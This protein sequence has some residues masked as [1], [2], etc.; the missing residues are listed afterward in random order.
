MVK[1]IIYSE[2]CYTLTVKEG[3]S[4]CIC[5]FLELSEE[6]FV[7]GNIFKFYFPREVM[8]NKKFISI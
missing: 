7:L 4:D 2:E 1:K 5:E 8:V 6:I 3:V